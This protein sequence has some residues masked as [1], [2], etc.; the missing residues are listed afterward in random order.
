MLGPQ[1]SIVCSLIGGLV[2]A[3]SQESGLVETVGLPMGLQTSSVPSI[4]SSP[5][6]SVG[7]SNFSLKVSC[8]YLHLSQSAASRA[9]QRTAI[10]GSCLLPSSCLNLSWFPAVSALWVKMMSL[11]NAI[12]A[13]HLSQHS[14]RQYLGNM[15]GNSF[16]NSPC[17]SCLEP[18]WRSSCTFATYE[19]GGLG[20]AHVCS[21]VGGSDSESPVGPG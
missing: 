18:T 21:L 17:S 4:F 8:K 7:V 13:V 20:P 3:S 10:V 11:Y 9:S 1:P 12:R 5:N 15:A 16:W 19:W 2:L 6:S 14:L